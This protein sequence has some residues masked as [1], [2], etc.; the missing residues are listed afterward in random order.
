MSEL[1]KNKKMAEMIWGLDWKKH[2]PI[3]LGDY[4]IELGNISDFLTLKNCPDSFLITSE[5]SS[6][7]FIKDIESRPK[8]AYLASACDF[9]LFKKNEE[10][11]GLFVGEVRD[12]CSYYIRYM[13]IEKHHR[14]QDLSKKLCLILEDILLQHTVDKI[15]I[16]IAPTN[17]KQVMRMSQLGYVSTGNLLSERFGACIQLTKFLKDEGWTVFNQN[18]MQIFYPSKK[19][20]AM[21]PSLD[22]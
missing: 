3:T 16:D 17:I 15:L 6:D 20:K 18:F 1:G 2:F 19:Q 21:M 8:E 11:V 9:F 10:T 5:T 14:S 7:S 13:S 12:W 4:Q 22:V